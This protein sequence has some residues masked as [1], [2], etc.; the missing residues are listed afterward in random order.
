MKV[1]I[2]TDDLKKLETAMG[3]YAMIMPTQKANSALRKASQPMFRAAQAEV[4]VGKMG[5]ERISLKKRGVNANA[6]RQG[7]ATKRDLRIKVVKAEPGEVSR[8]L[9]GV[10]KRSSKVGWRT[11]FITKGTK[12]RKTKKG[13]NRGSVKANNFLGRAFDSTIDFVR[14]DFQKAY[15]ES[16]VAW[17]RSTWPQI[18]V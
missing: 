14:A 17:A 11:P 10:S 7:G 2:N 9:V 6:Y 12:V 4:P 8:V 5:R 13:Y 16:F 3:K 18:G 1:T 15:R